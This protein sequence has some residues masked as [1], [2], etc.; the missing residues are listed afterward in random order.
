VSPVQRN[1]DL[2]NTYTNDNFKKK[3]SSNSSDVNHSIEKE[4][5]L[6]KY[7]TKHPTFLPD[8]FTGDE[9]DGLTEQSS[10]CLN[11]DLLKHVK[12]IGNKLNF[13]RSNLFIQLTEDETTFIR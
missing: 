2:T 5:P 1:G 11:D 10:G 7:R 8:D 3:L 6:I 12:T 13:N 9:T 4:N